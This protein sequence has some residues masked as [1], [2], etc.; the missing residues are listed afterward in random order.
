MAHLPCDAG[1]LSVLGSGGGERVTLAEAP[2]KC[3]R[4]APPPLHGARPSTSLRSQGKQTL[5]HLTPLVFTHLSIEA[6]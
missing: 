3:P 4:P 6:P 2:Q 5:S 1:D